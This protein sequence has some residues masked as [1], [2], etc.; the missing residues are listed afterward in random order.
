[1][2]SIPFCCSFSV[3]LI[4]HLTGDDDSNSGN[5][6][7]SLHRNRVQVPW[8]YPYKYIPVHINSKV[9][10]FVLQISNRT[11]FIS[12]VQQQLLVF[13]EY[14]FSCL[15][16]AAAAQSRERGNP[17]GK[18]LSSLSGV[19]RSETT[20]SVWNKEVVITGLH[21]GNARINE[22]SAPPSKKSAVLA[23]RIHRSKLFLVPW[24]FCKECAAASFSPWG[25]RAM[26]ILIIDQRKAIW[27][28]VD[29]TAAKG[30]EL[31]Q[32]SRKSPPSSP[33]LESKGWSG[34]EFRSYV[35]SEHDVT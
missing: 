3:L 29:E 34:A 21:G 4:L 8:T 1:M 13:W 25:H 16:S 22:E 20:L 17:W 9:I 14:Y 23:L 33:H 24:G 15:F 7:V 32:L 19:Y 2:G 5:I 18:H 28:I 10:T 27:H 30:G 31:F 6:N 35:N 26:V 11:R 12:M